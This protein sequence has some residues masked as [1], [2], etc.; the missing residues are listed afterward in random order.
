LRQREKGSLVF[1]K[2]KTQKSSF[3]LSLLWWSEKSLSK[4]CRPKSVS[5]CFFKTL[6]IRRFETLKFRD[7]I[8]VLFFLSFIR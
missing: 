3:R 2:K 7:A 8:F 4:L 5:P 6:N 1:G